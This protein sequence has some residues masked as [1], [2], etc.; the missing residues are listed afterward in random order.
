MEHLL[1]ILILLP[2]AG[3]LAMVLYSFAPSKRDEHYRWI[4]LIAT[5][6]TFILSLLLLSRFGTSGAEFKFEENVKL[7]RRDRRSLSP[8]R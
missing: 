3:A 2:F 7:D 4:A 5:V 1:T 6:A 8:R